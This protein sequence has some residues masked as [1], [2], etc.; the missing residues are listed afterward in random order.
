MGSR[1]PI[2]A[3]SHDSKQGRNT[4]YRKDA[5]GKTKDEAAKIQPPGL[6]T[7]PQ[8]RYQFLS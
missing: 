3:D 2:P 5:G 4:R 6:V 7:C 1:G 8:D